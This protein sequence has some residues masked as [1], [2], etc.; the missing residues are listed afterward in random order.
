MVAIIS[1][2]R[3]L[4]RLRNA[5]GFVDPLA[6]DAL[7]AE[8]EPQVVHDL[9]ER[10]G[11]LVRRREDELAAVLGEQRRD[12]LA[13]LQDPPDELDVPPAYR[14]PPEREPALQSIL[15]ARWHAGRSVAWEA[16]GVTRDI[17]ARDSG[18]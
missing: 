2:F 1:T 9:V 13:R 7:G 14:E 8:L 11:A 15:L 16:R 5:I 17:D 18:D 10:R 6:D 12:A 3:E 4:E